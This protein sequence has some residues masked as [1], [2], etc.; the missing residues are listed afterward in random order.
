[1]QIEAYLTAW[2]HF[3]TIIQEFSA[4]ETVDVAS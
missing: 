4:F 3:V 2:I 1:M